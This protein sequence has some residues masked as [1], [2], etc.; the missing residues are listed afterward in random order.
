M[1]ME[2]VERRFREKVCKD[3]RLEEEGIDRFRV[4]TP[5]KFDDGDHLSIVLKKEKERWILSDEGNTFMRLT[6]EIEES[7][8]SSG[9]R[10]TIIEN[11]LSMYG[12]V[13]RN[14]E[15]IIPIKNDNYGN[16]LYSFIQAI[17]RISDVSLLSREVV[18]STFLADLE[19]FVSDNVPEEFRAFEWFDTERDPERKYVVDCRVNS[20]EKPLMVFGL[21]NDDRTQVATITLLQFE[22]WGLKF[23][24]LG[25]FDNQ[26]TINR[27]VLARFSDVAEKQFSSLIVNKDKL[28]DFLREAFK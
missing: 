12:A 16:S 25:V 14:G 15:V 22:K 20:R 26:E 3:L 24:S 10:L 28:R 5:F 13:S 4:L 7:D 11:A 23:H 2:S 18:A 1:T 27:K 21:L 17:L 19:E 8:F 6:Y 9:N